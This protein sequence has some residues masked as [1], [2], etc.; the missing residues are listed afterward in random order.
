MCWIV[1]QT[2][3]LAA[4]TVR[5]QQLSYLSFGWSDAGTRALGQI[6]TC[7]EAACRQTIHAFTEANVGVPGLH[8][9]RIVDWT[10]VQLTWLN[11]MAG[12]LGRKFGMV[13]FGLTIHSLER[14]LHR[15]Q[16][17][18]AKHFEKGA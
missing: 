18:Q 12:R 15:G 4:E 5:P 7:L 11:D 2:V 14:I 8:R 10:S 1:E 3:T 9:A 17:G 6:D 13:L 16:M